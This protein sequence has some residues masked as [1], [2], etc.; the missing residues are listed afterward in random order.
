MIEWFIARMTGIAKARH[1]SLLDE[2]ARRQ[3]WPSMVW[4]L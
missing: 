1:E 3:P 2:Q 4:L